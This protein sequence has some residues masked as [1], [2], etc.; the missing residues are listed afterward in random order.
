MEEQQNIVEKLLAL[1]FDPDALVVQPR[2]VYRIHSNGLRYYYTFSE[3]GEPIFVPSVTTVIHKTM[4][5]SEYLIKWMAELGY[6]ESKE[7]TEKRA[8][9]GTIMHGCVA[10]LAIHKVIH[11]ASIKGRITSYLEAHRLPMIW[12]TEWE[13]EIKADVLAFARWMLDYN[14]KAIAIEISLVD[15]VQGCGMTIDMVCELDVE[16]KGY[17]GEVYKTGDRKGQPKESKR[18]ERKRAIVDFKSGRMGFYEEHA[19]Q[20]QAYKIAWDNINP[21]QPIEV[22]YNWSPKEWRKEPTYNFKDQTNATNAAAKW[23][24]FLRLA[25]LDIN[26]TS[27][28][29]MIL[30]GKVDLDTGNIDQNIRE[31]PFNEY[32]MTKHSEEPPDP[33]ENDLK[34]T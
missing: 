21:S 8:A 32:V 31:I 27:K 19:I 1:Y 12:A 14:V 10:D 23:E 2:Q 28:S 15:E 9:Y 20:L 18:I 4:P 26:V 6:E 7:Y 34:L 11:L 25:K 17:F 30:D 3:F 33:D 16:V 5:K 29:I 24:L 22:L 13:E